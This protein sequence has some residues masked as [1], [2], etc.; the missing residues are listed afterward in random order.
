[1]STVSLHDT[2]R[3]GIEHAAIRFG[4]ALVA[5]GERRERIDADRRELYLRQAGVRERQALREASA[6]SQLLP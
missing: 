4:R 5:W 3:F 1:M 2:R 6:R